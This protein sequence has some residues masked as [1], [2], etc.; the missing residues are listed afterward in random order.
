[1]DAEFSFD[2]SGTIASVTDLATAAVDTVYSLL[3]E[4]LVEIGIPEQHAMLSSQL[5]LTKR[6]QLTVEKKNP[7]FE[8][9]DPLTDRTSVTLIITERIPQRPV[10]IYE[11]LI[12]Y[13]RFFPTPVVNILAS[14]IVFEILGT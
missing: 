2:L 13:T 10:K 12:R 5:D 8:E 7:T 3:P 6:T 11:V 14:S 9:L 4:A 1:M